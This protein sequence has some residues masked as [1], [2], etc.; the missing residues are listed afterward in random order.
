M[1]KEPIDT[2]TLRRLTVA[3]QEAL[4]CDIH[5]LAGFIPACGTHEVDINEWGFCP[6]AD[7]AAD[8]AIKILKRA[9]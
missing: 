4:D 2:I 8:T 7:K 1:L 3:M 6:V 5:E 9:I